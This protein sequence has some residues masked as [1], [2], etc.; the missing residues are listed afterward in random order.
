[1]LFNNKLSSQIGKLLPGD[2]LVYLDIYNRLLDMIQN[3]TKHGNQTHS[4]YYI[5]VT[6]IHQMFDGNDSTLTS[7]LKFYYIKKIVNNYFIVLQ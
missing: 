2:R 4:P 3:P 7:H 6:Y 5:L 1:M